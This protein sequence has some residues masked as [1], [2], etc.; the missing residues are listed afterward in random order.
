[1]GVRGKRGQD[2]PRWKGL[3][4]FLPPFD[5]GQS[6]FSLR[7]RVSKERDL[8]TPIFLLF[9]GEDN[10]SPIV[11]KAAS[12]AFANAGDN[13]LEQRRASIEGPQP[14]LCASLF[15]DTSA[16]SS[17]REIRSAASKS[18]HDE[19]DR[20]FEWIVLNFGFVNQEESWL[21][22]REYLN[23]CNFQRSFGS[24]FFFLSFVKRRSKVSS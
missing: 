23:F 13:W 3:P 21:G 8:Q 15:V 2:L 10:D 14:P 20:S 4:F 19:E 17:P 24:I 12:I 6:R 22:M 7:K 11:T 18:D 9:R 16:I 5:V 1:M